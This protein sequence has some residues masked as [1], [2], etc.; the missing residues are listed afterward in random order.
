MNKQQETQDSSRK[1]FD[2]SSINALGWRA[3]IPLREGLQRMY[4]DFLEH[5]D[6]IRAQE[7]AQHQQPS[8]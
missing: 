8:H 7:G 2:V 4:A 5:Y 3:S 6:A 1:L